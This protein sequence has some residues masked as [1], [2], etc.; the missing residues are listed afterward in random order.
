MTELKMWL[1]GKI[2]FY[3]ELLKVPGDSEETAYV[4]GVL[5]AYK[6]VMRQLE[7]TK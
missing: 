2:T 6:E 4:E 7:K 1:A 3:D 5:S